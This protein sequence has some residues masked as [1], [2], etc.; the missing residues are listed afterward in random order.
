MIDEILSR[1]GSASH[2]TFT[3][4][5]AAD[6]LIV[7]FVVY[8][9]LRLI[10]GTRAV[11]MVFGLIAILV[12]YWISVILKLVALRT[13]LSALIFYLPFAIIVLF[14]QELRRALAAFG[15]TPFFSLFTGYHAEETVSD[16]VLA[17]TSL[18]NKKVGALIVLERREGLKTYIENGVPVDAAISYDLLVNLFSPGTPL[19][20]GAVI[21]SRERI[22]AAACFLPLS[23]KEGLSKRFGTRH[24]AAIG[25]TE[26]T[27]ALAIVVSEERGTISL[28]RDGQLVEDLDGKA[29]RDLLYRE[30]AT[31]A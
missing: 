1:F 3:W 6:I 18:S 17:A 19:H 12:V 9:L 22:A 23:L 30:F 21:V 15:R 2:F 31:S 7:A 25:V 26:E 16:L 20:D 4:R 14:S 24:R 13:V 29:L 11:Q 27:D 10:R 5:D 28:A 8:F